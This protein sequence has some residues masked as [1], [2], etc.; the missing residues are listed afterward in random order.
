MLKLFLFI[1]LEVF[2]FDKFVYCIFFCG[3]YDDEFDGDFL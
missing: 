1:M 2:E 3:I